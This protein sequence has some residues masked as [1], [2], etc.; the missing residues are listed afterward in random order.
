MVSLQKFTRPQL[1]VK[2]NSRNRR[3]YQG[4]DKNIEQATKWEVKL[5]GSPKENEDENQ[6]SKVRLDVCRDHVAITSDSG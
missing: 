4:G 5:R 6:K 3:G 1:G 2:S